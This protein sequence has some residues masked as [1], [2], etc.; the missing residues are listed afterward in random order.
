MTP[1]VT[2]VKAGIDRR[3]QIGAAFSTFSFCYLVGPVVHGGDRENLLDSDFT[4]QAATLL[5]SQGGGWRF[6]VTLLLA[7]Q[8]CMAERHSGWP[9]S[10][11]IP[12]ILNSVVFS[13]EPPSFATLTLLS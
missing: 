5:Q 6:L 9:G 1:P 7:V 2:C 13:I 3:S 10:M 4:F 8:H 12:S 11:S